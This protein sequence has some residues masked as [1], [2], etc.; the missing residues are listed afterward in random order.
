LHIVD[1]L[2]NLAVE[3]EA[4]FESCALLKGFAG[5]VLIGPETGIADQCLQ[6]IK[7]TLAGAGVKGTSGRRRRGF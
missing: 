1:L 2:A 5:A 6:S 4:F 3:S 7:L